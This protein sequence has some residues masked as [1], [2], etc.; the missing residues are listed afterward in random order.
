M[1]K[2]EIYEAP[3]AKIVSLDAVDVITESIPF[4]DPN[5]LPDGWLLT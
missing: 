5:I 3:E 4:E 1:K 2:I